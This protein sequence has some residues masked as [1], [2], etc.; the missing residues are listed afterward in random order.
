MARKAKAHVEA[1]RV[2]YTPSPKPGKALNVDTEKL[3]SEFYYDDEISRYMP[4]K[5][6]F[7]S[8]KEHGKEIHKQKQLL[9]C[10]LNEA[11]SFKQ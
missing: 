3:V 6:D 5:K 9:L 10:N 4:G 11:Y 7:A 1:K 8:V 2:L